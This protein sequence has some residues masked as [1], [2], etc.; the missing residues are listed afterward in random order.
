MH[1]PALRADVHAGKRK[2][3]G[4]WTEVRGSVSYVEAGS[5]PGRA[6]LTSRI[7]HKI[8]DKNAKLTIS[9]S[10]TRRGRRAMAEDGR[11]ATNVEPAGIGEDEGPWQGRRR[12]WVFVWPGSVVPCPVLKVER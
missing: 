11:K 7:A 9:L 8:L 6:P 4:V 12:P 2:G 1:G 10:N 3:R 5:D